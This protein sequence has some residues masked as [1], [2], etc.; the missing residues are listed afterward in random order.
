MKVDE[1][2]LWEKLGDGQTGGSSAWNRNRPYFAEMAVS[3][4]TSYVYINN[5]S[6]NISSTATDT[7]LIINLFKLGQIPALSV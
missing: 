4:I 5:A 7:D 1:D 2:Y 3:N 6:H